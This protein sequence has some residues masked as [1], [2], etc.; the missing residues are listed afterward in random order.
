MRAVLVA[1]VSLAGVTMQ[2]CGGGG[3]SSPSLTAAAP[4]ASTI[5]ASPSYQAVSNLIKTNY[6]QISATDYN[7]STTPNFYYSTDNQAFWSIQANVAASLTDINA[8]T[9]FRIDVPKVGQLPQ[10]NRSFSIESGGEYEQFPGTFYVLDGQQATRKKVESGVINFTP[11]SVM[12]GHVSGSFD[13]TFSDY[14]S[15]LTPAPRYSLKG[16]FSFKMGE[17]APAS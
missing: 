2:G 16:V 8:R 10:F 6:M 4:Q 13:V 15:T 14:D 5:S 12:S 9:V 17:S 7:F 3:G 11:D 1:V